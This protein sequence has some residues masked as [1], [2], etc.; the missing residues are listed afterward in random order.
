MIAITG[1]RSN[2]NMNSKEIEESVASNNSDAKTTSL[3]A[4]IFKGWSCCSCLFEEKKPEETT[5]TGSRVQVLGDVEEK[6]D[7]TGVDRYA[8]RRRCLKTAATLTAVGLLALGFYSGAIK[9]PTQESVQAF[10]SKVFEG[11][12]VAYE[13]AKET[14][15]DLTNWFFSTA[16]P[17]IEDLVSRVAV[18]AQEN[19]TQENFNIVFQAVSERLVSLGN[20]IVA[21][22]AWLQEA[23]LEYLRHR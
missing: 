3:G 9:L 1:S 18:F 4:S 23:A 14:V 6:E 2:D 12:K 17:V 8:F 7:V 13:C 20:Q 5:L 19:F 10:A 16:Y 22:G 15:I 11:M 21:T